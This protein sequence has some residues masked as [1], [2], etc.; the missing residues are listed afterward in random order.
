MKFRL[1]DNQKKNKHRNQQAQ[2]HGDDGHGIFYTLHPNVGKYKC[3][4]GYVSPNGID[5]LTSME[6]RP[7]RLYRALEDEIRKFGMRPT[8]SVFLLGCCKA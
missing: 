1:I 5:E 4:C 3:T 2:E 7:G 8:P 6:R